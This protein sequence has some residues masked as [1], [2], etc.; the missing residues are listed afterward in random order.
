MHGV[1]LMGKDITRA[2]VPGVFHSKFVFLGRQELGNQ[3]QG[4][5]VAAGDDDLFRVAANA[6]EPLQILAE[7]LP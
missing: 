7:L 6:A 3:T 4:V 1:S 2:A 5:M